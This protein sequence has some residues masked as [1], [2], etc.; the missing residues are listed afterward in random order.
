[1]R[2]RITILLVLANIVV[3]GFLWQNLNTPRDPAVP[4]PLF[5]ADI[6]RIVVGGR[7]VAQPY[8]VEAD[9]LGNWRLTAPYEWEA[10]PAAIEL[11]RNE[12]RYFNMDGSF[13]LAE[14]KA[15]GSPISFYGLDAPE[16]TVSVTTA[17]APAPTVI[18]FGR[19]SG[20][21]IY[22]LAPAADG[23][24]DNARVIPAPRRLR[25]ILVT[26]PD[27]TL[28]SRSVFT[29]ESFEV[30]N[31]TVHVS[32]DTASDIPPESGADNS[33]QFRIRRAE[34][35]LPESAD[36]EHI[37]RFETP[38][39]ANA[40]KNQLQGALARLVKLP[41]IKFI[42]APKGERRE[43][44]S[45]HGLETPSL[46]L[47]IEAGNNT[48]VLRV[49]KRDP[50]PEGTPA[51]FARLERNN[52]VF[53]VAESAVKEWREA[54]NFREEEFLHFFPA[55]LTEI[56]I[57]EG[58][59][60][61]VLHR[62]DESAKT[63][64]PANA[65]APDED[66]SASPATRNAIGLSAAE[67]GEWSILALPGTDVKVPLTA[68]PAAMR[69][70][71]ETL[72]YIRAQ[73]DFSGTGATPDRRRL[74]SAF[75]TDT[76]S[77]NELRNWGFEKPARR[78]ELYFK[79]APR[80]ALLIA[81]PVA[82]DTPPHAKLEDAPSVYSIRRNLP[83]AISASPAK[84][85]NRLVAR[86]PAQNITALR[87]T[88][89]KTNTVVLDLPT[90]AK[91]KTPD[92]PAPTAAPTTAAPTTA[93]PTTAAPTTPSPLT[94]LTPLLAGLPPSAQN[95]IRALVE[96]LGELRAAAFDDAPFSA[97]F[98][99]KHAGF[100][101]P[102][103]WLYRLDITLRPAGAA[104]DETVALYFSKRLDGITQIAGAPAQDCVFK[105]T[106]PLIDALFP[107]TFE[108]ERALEI[109]PIAPP[110]P[111]PAPTEPPKS[112][113]ATPADAKK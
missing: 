98:K 82:A 30:R 57:Y 61:L 54:R 113:P 22:L 36:I 48:Q 76:P 41:L 106:Q 43:F 26:N 2:F 50:N 56:G 104:N 20:E 14:A 90:S 1:M 6:R 103:P 5:G 42:P 11:L 12:L 64:T 80:R 88:N 23:N 53:T 10:D 107:L 63:E 49:G 19:E 77:V 59:R 60:K 72:R 111:I 35:P 101:E 3:F 81:A 46:V 13:T 67:I 24:P 17:G 4:G 74:Y 8:T 94:P 62:R 87:I 95:D 29:I 28:R 92:A 55:A 110:P 65:N 66:A 21:K 16:V 9:R 105:I 58:G 108:K 7:G 73:T 52:A 68:D 86:L 96:C 40:N 51:Y 99:Y 91:N 18:H 100:Q 34:R 32:A 97:D 47:A 25:D 83:D 89:L 75:V 37:W 15:N 38:F 112:P 85:R 33:V 39:T 31:I 27:K 102:F 45:R 84:Y 44:F 71:V 79:N 78:V 109:P 69:S 70:L 93:A